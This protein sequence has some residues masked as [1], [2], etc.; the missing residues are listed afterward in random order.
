MEIFAIVML[1]LIILG[2]QHLL[3][4]GARSVKTQ[5]DVS[6]FMIVSILALAVTIL[7]I[8]QIIIWGQN[9]IYV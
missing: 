1:V 5:N 9:I 2:I 7:L 3:N 6:A 8:Y 4:W